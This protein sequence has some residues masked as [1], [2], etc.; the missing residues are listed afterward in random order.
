MSL[1]FCTF[2]DEIQYCRTYDMTFLAFPKY[3]FHIHDFLHGYIKSALLLSAQHFMKQ[4]FPN[5]FMRNH[6]R[7]TS[8]FSAQCY[9]R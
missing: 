8:I 1:S 9:G 2:S 4:V 3:A 6:I 7:I 5:L